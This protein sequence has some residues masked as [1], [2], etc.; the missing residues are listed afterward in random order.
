[1]KSVPY[2]PLQDK[3]PKY[4]IKQ[5]ADLTGLPVSTV[6]YYDKAGLLPSVIRT[7]GNVR[8]FSDHSAS[9][10]RLIHALRTTGLPIEKVRHYIALCRKGDPTI[11]ERAAIIYEQEET[12]RRQMRELKRQMEVLNY[13]KSYYRNLQGKSGVDTCN[14]QTNAKATTL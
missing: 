14:P 10:L 6:R 8:M 13:K 1:M 2:Q 5:I 12:L 9:W 7:I 4:T 3:T 11:N